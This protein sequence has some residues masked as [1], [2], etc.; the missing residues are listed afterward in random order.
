MLDVADLGTTRVRVSMAILV[1]VKVVA[2]KAL[3]AGLHVLF[4]WHRFSLLTRFSSPFSIALKFLA[5]LYIFLFGL[6][7]SMLGEGA[8]TRDLAVHIDIG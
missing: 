6:L 3:K 4:A 2:V 8:L 5:C 1:N 7:C